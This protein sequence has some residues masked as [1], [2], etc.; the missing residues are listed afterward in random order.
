MR[1]WEGGDGAGD[2]VLYGNMEEGEE[3]GR[4]LVFR[5]ILV[6]NSIV[7]HRLWRRDMW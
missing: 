3:G 2:G 4:I 1:G 6:L 5:S 7:Y